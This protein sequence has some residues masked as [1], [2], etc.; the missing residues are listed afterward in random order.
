MYIRKLFATLLA[1]SA[2][3]ASAQSD[4]DFLYESMPLCDKADF[5]RE[6]FE[7]NA[8]LTR[9]AVAEMP[10]G[11]QLDET[12]IRHFV[13]PLR[14]NNEPLDSFRIKYYDTLKARV[15]GMN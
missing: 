15:S 8:A 2:L 10:W 6:F 1:V 7:T 14:V 3:T 11:S 4:V 5:S 12:L 9:R 13:L